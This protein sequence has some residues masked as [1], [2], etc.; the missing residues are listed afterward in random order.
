MLVDLEH[1]GGA[2]LYGQMTLLKD[3]FTL[4][5]RQGLYYEFSDSLPVYSLTL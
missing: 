5:L 3:Q 4:S 1:T 2:G